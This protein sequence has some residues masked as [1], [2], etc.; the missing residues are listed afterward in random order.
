MFLPVGLEETNGTEQTVRRDG[1]AKRADDCQPG[2]PTGVQP[3]RPPSSSYKLRVY[4]HRCFRICRCVAASSGAK[5][6]YPSREVGTY[7]LRQGRLFLEVFCRKSKD[8][9]IVCTYSMPELALG[10]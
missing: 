5:I 3:G 10:A 7:L 4:S 8:K 9:A 2:P 6:V 1:E